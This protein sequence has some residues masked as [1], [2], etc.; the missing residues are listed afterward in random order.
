MAF[1]QVLTR[2][3]RTKVVIVLSHNRNDMLAKRV[4]VPPVARPTTLAGHQAR[5][6][7]APHSFQESENLPTLQ[8]K[9]GGCI[10]DPQFAALNT[11][12]RV[13]AVAAR[14]KPIRS[15]SF[16]PHVRKPLSA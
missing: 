10:F 9:Q 8:S 2:Q 15:L 13:K 3:G 16:S 11:H 7:V 12:Q 4:A 14:L 5:S 6:A 1:Y